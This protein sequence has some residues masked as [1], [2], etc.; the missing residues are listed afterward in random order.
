M[1]QADASGWTALH[2]CSCNGNN[3]LVEE[4]C[5]LGS[6]INCV[7]SA[8]Q[9]P[10]H[11]A[12]YSGSL[13][14][15]HTLLRYRADVNAETK[16]ERNQ[17]IH[18]ACD[19]NFKKITVCLLE[20]GAQI[21]A[22][23][24]LERTPL[25]LAAAVGRVDIAAYLIKHGAKINALDVHG[26]TP[27]QVAELNSHRDVQE[28]LVRANMPE[29]MPVMKDLPAAPWHGELWTSLIQS[30]KRN[31]QEY[32]VEKQKQDILKVEV[33]AYQQ[34]IA[35]IMATTGG[36]NKKFEK[37]SQS[38]VSQ[39]EIIV[40]NGIGDI[41][42]QEIKRVSRHAHVRNPESA[43]IRVIDS[44]QNQTFQQVRSS[45]TTV[46]V[47]GKGVAIRANESPAVV[48][49][50]RIAS[51]RARVDGR[52]SRGDDDNVSTVSSLTAYSH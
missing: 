31:Y 50:K 52:D 5:A 37:P 30:Q 8:G 32:E 23:N 33:A 42:E 45:K 35:D 21:N 20:H 11:L 6:V 1:L 10:L 9:T 14:T 16:F 22:K 39:C 27:R 2:S 41:L 12:V 29:K 18:I 7:N 3:E 49:G 28:L 15:V 48:V 25:H 46:L 17:P 40:D 43:S 44:R 13:E 36:R 51:R 26:W 19:R 24:V 47:S 38:H 34:R 4:L